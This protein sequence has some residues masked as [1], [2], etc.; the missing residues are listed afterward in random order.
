VYVTESP[1]T[2][3]PGLGAVT[4]PC[5]GADGATPQEFAVHEGA[6]LHE[7]LVWHVAEAGP[8]RV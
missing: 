1:V 8:V 6:A 7:P 5:A 2:P 3:E 4:A